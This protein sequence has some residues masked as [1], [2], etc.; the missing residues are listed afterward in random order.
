MV[1]ATSEEHIKLV[2]LNWL[3]STSDEL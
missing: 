2:C 1:E 3:S